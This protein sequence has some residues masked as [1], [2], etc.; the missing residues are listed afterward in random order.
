[1]ERIFL[2][3]GHDLEMRAI[4]ELL[5]SHNE[6]FFDMDLEWNNACLSAYAHLL[7]GQHEFF[8]IELQD[9]IPAPANYHRIDHHNELPP[10]PTAL[11]QV[12]TLLNVTLNR[13]QQLVAT[14][15]YGYIPAMLAFGATDGEITQIRQA[16]RRE[17]GVTA[18]DEQLAA[19]SI[20]KN[21]TRTG[22]LIIVKALTG[23]FSAICDRLYPFKNL[24]LYTESELT[25]YGER[26]IFVL[27]Q[28]S[29]TLTPNSTY[30]GGGATGYWGIAKG[31]H[32]PNEIINIVQHIQNLF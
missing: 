4:E 11:E 27:T 16:D 17:Q 15:D 25:F 10:V 28:L 12:A 2:L 13:W 1:M 32:T 26:K 19:D 8:G 29:N 20:D 23:K 21:L 24:L 14:N 22:D 7:D 30:Q 18:E 9:D 3:G 6:T 31:M 5:C